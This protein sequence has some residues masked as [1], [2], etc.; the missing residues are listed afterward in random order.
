MLPAM[1][2]ISH[3]CP[4]PSR[5][6]TSLPAWPGLAHCLQLTVRNLQDLSPLTQ[7]DDPLVLG[8]T[9]AGTLR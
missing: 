4:L 3:G 5:I 7:R 6:A 1:T 2:A 8:I 9:H